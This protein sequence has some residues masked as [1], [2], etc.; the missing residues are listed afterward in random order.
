MSAGGYPPSFDPQAYKRRNVVERAI[1][2]L[3]DFR[4][5][6]TRYDKRGY[7]YLATVAVA[8]V[9]QWLFQN[10]SGRPWL[11]CSCDLDGESVNRWCSPLIVRR[12]FH[13]VLECP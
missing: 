11:Q 2:R 1:N 5:V 9:L 4:A 12:V 13:L 3:K 8:I 10:Q 7:P 6:A